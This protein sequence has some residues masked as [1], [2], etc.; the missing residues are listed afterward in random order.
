M[1]RF[2]VV[3]ALVASFVSASFTAAN[4]ARA[5]PRE[6]SFYWG[7]ATSGFQS[8][9]YAPDSNWK[10]YVDKTAGTNGVD[11]YGNS[12]D[13]RH[14]YAQ[15]IQLARNLGVNTFRFGVE[16]AR[17][18]PK[19]GVWDDTE[20]AYYDD[21][22]KHILAAGMTPMIT[23]EHFTEPGWATD[24]GSWA[25]DRTVADYL[26][27]TQRIVQRYRGNGVLWI[28]FNEPLVLLRHELTVGSLRWWQL[29]A[30][31]SNVVSAHR[32]AY[33]LIHELDPTA[34][35]TSNQAFISGFNDLTDLFFLDRFA[36][37]LDFIGIDYYYGLS[38]DN[39]TAI[40]AGSGDF[41]KVKLQPEGIYYALR[42]YHDRYP[43]LPLYI[44][45]NGMPTDNGKPRDAGY[46]R[47]DNL[48]DTIYWVQ[49]AKAD[50]INVIGYNYWS[51]TDNYE[52]GTY[53]AR[54]GLYTVDVLTDPA[55]ARTPT[56]AVPA[57]TAITAKGG[58][59]AGYRLHRQP[60]VCSLV[61]TLSSCLDPA[62]VNGPVATLR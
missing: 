49:R 33:D 21:V 34:K 57:Y 37:K 24:Q 11:P 60:G 62:R 22:V 9:G 7:V 52:W 17:V 58:V 16:W 2:F 42:N 19:P 53:R 23:L 28:T 29:A 13:F 59:P 47:A 48:R 15:D 41:W 20:L 1:S 36:D 38:L 35:V 55:L 26:A 45:E 44:V 14:R 10:R 56:D 25:S 12:A 50:G 61:D 8:E 43:G 39:L 30:A 51:L 32:Q 46:T 54:F 31:R 6:R 27:Y 3:I 5:Q 4:A 40:S 18:E